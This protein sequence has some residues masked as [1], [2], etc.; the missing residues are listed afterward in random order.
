MFQFVMATLAVLLFALP[1]AT[2]YKIVTTTKKLSIEDYFI[3][4]A[5]CGI[6][7]LICVVNLAIQLNY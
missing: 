7:Y 2:T 3:A 4:C 6:S 5:F 1:I